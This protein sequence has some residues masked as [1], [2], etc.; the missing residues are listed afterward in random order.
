[1]LY[2]GDPLCS[3]QAVYLQGTLWRC[4][5]IFIMTTCN[6]RHKSRLCTQRYIGITFLNFVPSDNVFKVFDVSP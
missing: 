5:I 2:V 4:D 1:V 6:E 3:V